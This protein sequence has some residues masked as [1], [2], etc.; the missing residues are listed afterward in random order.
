MRKVQEDR[1]VLLFHELNTPL[2]V[3]VAAEFG[4]RPVRKV[5]VGVWVGWMS[6]CLRGQ[7]DGLQS[8]FVKEL[9]VVEALP[10]C[11]H[12]RSVYLSAAG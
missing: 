12:I 6:E 10:T 3:I 5:N 7:V 11:Q 4:V 1:A 9:S 8:L 2:L